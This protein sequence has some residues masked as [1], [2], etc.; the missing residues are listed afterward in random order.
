MAAITLEEPRT[1]APAVSATFFVTSA[2]GRTTEQDAIQLEAVLW[3]PERLG[4][5]VARGMGDVSLEQGRRH[6]WFKG[7][8]PM[9]GR[10]LSRIHRRY[11]FDRETFELLV[12][13]PELP[14]INPSD[15]WAVR[16]FVRV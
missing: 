16:R 2:H 9:G 15:D 10:M 8:D 1:E 4:F 6:D 3:A 12:R 13:D 14:G 5:R 11:Q 7:F